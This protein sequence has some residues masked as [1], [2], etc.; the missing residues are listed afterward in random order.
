MRLRTLCNPSSAN[1]DGT[2]YFAYKI[3][4]FRRKYSRAFSAIVKENVTNAGKTKY[5]FNEAI[6]THL[7][8][9]VKTFRSIVRETKDGN[10]YLIYD[11]GT[12][13]K[14]M[15]TVLGILEAL[16]VV[17]FKMLGGAN[18]QL[19][20]YINQTRSLENA[21]QENHFTRHDDW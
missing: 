11:G 20:I 6:N 18:S 2:S 14:E 15:G 3:D 17:S 9:L 13:L 8:W 4:A 19:Y 21:I 5:L 1:V 10:L 12:M 7:S 16:D